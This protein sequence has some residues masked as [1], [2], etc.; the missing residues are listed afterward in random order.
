MFD[1]AGISHLDQLDIKYC[2]PNDLRGWLGCDVGTSLDLIRFANED[3][4]NI[5]AGNLTIFG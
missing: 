1:L 4:E 2:T 5:A 3:L